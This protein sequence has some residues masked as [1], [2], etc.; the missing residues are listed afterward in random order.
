MINLSRELKVAFRTGKVVYGFKRV[1][2]LL[3][4]KKVAGVIVAKNARRDIV[5]Q[6]RYYARISGVPIYLFEGD[7]WDLGRLIEKPFMVSSIAII[8][9]GESEITSLFERGEEVA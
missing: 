8:D 2:T 3:L 5:E 9:P 6:L 7:S 1:K 4:S